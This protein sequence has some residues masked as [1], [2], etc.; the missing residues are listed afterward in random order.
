MKRATLL[1]LL[2]ANETFVGLTRPALEAVLDAGALRHWARDAYL[3]QQGD[4]ASRF[5][6]IVR[7]TA[8]LVQVT[9]D[10]HQVIVRFIVRGQE[11][12]LIAALEGFV[13]P[14]S[15]QAAP[16][17][18]LRPC[19]NEQR[20]GTGLSHTL[21]TPFINWRY[22]VLCLRLRKDRRSLFPLE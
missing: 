18:L 20:P 21:F 1:G 17:A 6:L 4:P 8:K 9:P 2:A 10:G 19:A 15:I 14:L 5:A 7:G 22:F 13:Y 11:F 12:G 3:I 16:S